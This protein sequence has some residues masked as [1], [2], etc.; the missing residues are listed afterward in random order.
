MKLQPLVCPINFTQNVILRNAS[1][2]ESGVVGP[3]TDSITFTEYLLTKHCSPTGCF[4]AAQHDNIICAT[5]VGLL[6]RNQL[7]LH[8]LAGG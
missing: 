3:A 7:N 1:D 4:A 8:Q 5:P 6:Q 2:E